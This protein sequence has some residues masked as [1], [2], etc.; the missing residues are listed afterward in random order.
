MA[1]AK[2][3]A[4]RI[5]NFLLPT[6]VAWSAAVA[7]IPRSPLLDGAVGAAGPDGRAPALPYRWLGRVLAHSRLTAADPLT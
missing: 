6:E 4:A 5:R 3:I 2:I 7:A 1:T